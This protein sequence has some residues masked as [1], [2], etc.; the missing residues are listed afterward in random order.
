M[1]RWPPILMYHAVARHPYDPNNVCVSPGRFKAQML[2][3]KR[4]GLRGVS[5]DE[6]T[7]AI[8]R[9]EAESLVGLTFDDG[10]ENFLHAA[11]PVLKACGFNATVFVLGGMLGEKN[12]W[13]KAPRMRLLDA[14]GVR[15]VAARGVEIGT[16]GMSHVRLPG[17]DPES[18]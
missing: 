9:G 13:D 6:L 11:L 10:Y 17:L 18:L 1:T 12:L 2:Y 14:D 3:L 15:E 8:G 16:H 7:R 4:R 5:V